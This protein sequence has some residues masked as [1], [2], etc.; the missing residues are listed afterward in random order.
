[1]TPGRPGEFNPNVYP[2]S[3]V[4]DGLNGQIDP[5]CQ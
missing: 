5:L 2:D 4:A 1:M 3:G